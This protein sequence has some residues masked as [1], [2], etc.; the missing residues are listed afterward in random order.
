MSSTVMLVLGASTWRIEDITF[1]RV[2]VS[3]APG[4][5]GK[6]PFWHGDRPGR[7][8]ELG[9]ALGGFVREMRELGHNEASAR[10]QE[11]Y[12][13]DE[14]AANN[15]LAYL[16]DQVAAT[17]AVP[18][19]RTVVVER[20]RD[21][22]GDWRVCLLSPFGTPV[23]APWAMAIERKLADAYDMPVETMWG[24]DGIVA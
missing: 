23:H 6:M 22:I 13:L 19:D 3:P 7:P 10:L 1:E 17:G 24:D 11:H 9:R 14:R 18:D 15:L 12:A 8:L 21:E 20:F 5:P 4:Q 16:A 2:T